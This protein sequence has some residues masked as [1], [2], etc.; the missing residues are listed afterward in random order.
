MR[1]RGYRLLSVWGLASALTRGP[2]AVLR[3]LIRRVVIRLVMRL[4]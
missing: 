4:F 3:W 1:R 2:V